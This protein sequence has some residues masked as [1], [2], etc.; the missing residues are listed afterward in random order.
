MQVSEEDQLP[1]IMCG[2][3]SYKLDLFN[4][5]RDKAY[6]TETQ[7]LAKAHANVVDLK[8]EVIFL[9]LSADYLA[10]ME[11]SLFCPIK[12]KFTHMIVAV[13]IMFRGMSL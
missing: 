6:K 8:D 3:C 12:I 11:T 2:E 5:F 4:F 10:L 1:K 9:K 13:A 7:L